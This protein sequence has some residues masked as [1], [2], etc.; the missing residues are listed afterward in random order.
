MLDAAIGVPG[1]FVLLLLGAPYVDRSPKGVGKWFSR[2]RLL[3]LG[4]HLVQGLHA[5]VQQIDSKRVAVAMMADL[6]EWN[7]VLIESRRITITAAPGDQ[8][9]RQ[10]FKDNAKAV[11]AFRGLLLAHAAAA[12]RGRIAGPASAA[13]PTPRT[14]VPSARSWARLRWVAGCVHISRFMAGA[15]SSGQRSPSAWAATCSVMAARLSSGRASR[16]SRRAAAAF[17]RIPG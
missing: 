2:D 10:R 9:V 7:K 12:S 15:T 1:I 3:A 5:R 14:T 6:V 4:L 17:S 13:A 16:A 11:Q 8:A